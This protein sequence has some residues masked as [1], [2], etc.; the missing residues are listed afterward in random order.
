MLCCAKKR[1]VLPDSLRAY[2]HCLALF[3]QFVPRQRRVCLMIQPPQSQ[4]ERMPACI[5]YLVSAI[6]ILHIF[7]PHN[8]PFQQVLIIPVYRIRK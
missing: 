4:R 2:E 7:S 1:A 6:Y 3:S 5:E 8:S